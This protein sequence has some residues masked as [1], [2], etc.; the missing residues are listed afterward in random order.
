MRVDG[1]FAKDL[2]FESHS[3]FDQSSVFGEPSVV[4]TGTESEPMSGG[5]KSEPRNNGYIDRFG[6]GRIVGR[7]QIP[8]GPGSIKGQPGN[9]IAFICVL[10]IIRGTTTEI[11]NA[12]R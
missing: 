5:R 2:K 12:S 1:D 6:P 7:C 3:D 8:I 4:I 11:A 10:L 9:R